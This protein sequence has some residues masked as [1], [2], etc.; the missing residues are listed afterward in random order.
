MKRKNKALK[1][2]TF[3]KCI[4]CDW[5]QLHVKVPQFNFQEISSTCYTIKEETHGTQQ[6]KRLFR[7]YEKDRET[8]EIAVLAAFPRADVMLTEN[9][10]ILKIVN[11]YL[12]QSDLESFVRFFLKELNLS[13]VNITR[14][15]AA[16]DFEN[17]DG[18]RPL[19]FIQMFADRKLY[20][21]RKSNFRLMGETFSVDSGKETGGY[22]SLKFGKQTSNLTYQLYNKSLELAKV[23]EK[24][25]IYDHWR[26]NGWQGDSQVWRLE[27]NIWSHPEGLALVD[28]DGTICDKI[29][30]NDLGTISKIA[31]L[32]VFFFNRN[33]GFCYKELTKKGNIKK[34]SRS[35]QLILFQDL[36]FIPGVKIKVSDKKDAGRSEKIF[37]RHLEKLN[38]ELRGRDFELGVFFNEALTWVVETRA[39]QTWAEKK[40][41]GYKPSERI[42]EVLQ[43]GKASQWQILLDHE[44]KQPKIFDLNGKSVAKNGTR[45][46]YAWDGARS[47]VE[48]E[49][50]PF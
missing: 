27:F 49:E 46:V 38:N 33:F 24:P 16:L 7:I 41:S 9:S 35:T 21:I 39:L 15:D 50:A 12:Y 36:T 20:K 1:L 23:K 26:A 48:W 28:D 25:W 17:F 8:E 10:G 3:N 31:E 2:V 30:F 32:W 44:R 29:F 34:Q 37:V 6:F 47:L 42:V 14:I 45:Y 18:L 19:R 43:K 5:L 13:F 40:L 4:A 22:E 11:K